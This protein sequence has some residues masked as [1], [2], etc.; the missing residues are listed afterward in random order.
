MTMQK[1]D[2]WSWTDNIAHFRGHRVGL[3]TV[4][5]KETLM[6]LPVDILDSSGSFVLWLSTSWWPLGCLDC[7]IFI[8]GE[9]TQPRCMITHLGTLYIVHTS[10]SVKYRIRNDNIDQMCFIQ[11]QTKKQSVGLKHY[12]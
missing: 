4:T 3:H 8:K 2:D 12:H 7:E 6:M 11:M 10:N 5:Y 9:Y 1:R